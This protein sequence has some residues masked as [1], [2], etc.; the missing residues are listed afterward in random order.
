MKDYLKKN[1]VMVIMT[2]LGLLSLL[3]LNTNSIIPYIINASFY[4]SLFF[5]SVYIWWQ[6]KLFE[7]LSDISKKRKESI[8]EN[9]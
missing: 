2:I 3:V 9:N 6:D 5:Y 1:W 4:L 7:E 8:N